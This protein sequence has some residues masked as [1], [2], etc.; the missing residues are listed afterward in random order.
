MYRA[1]AD[2]PP[3]PCC[4]PPPTKGWTEL[5]PATQLSSPHAVLGGREPGELG[6]SQVLSGRHGMAPSLLQHCPPRHR[7]RCVTPAVGHHNLS[8]PQSFT[9]TRGCAGPR[10]R[11]GQP[12]SLP[13]GKPAAGCASTRLHTLLCNR[14]LRGASSNK[15]LERRK[16]N[17]KSSCENK[18]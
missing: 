6:C 5:V 12:R 9:N 2:T 18:D 3:Q 10:C 11:G 8:R 7:T 14:L 13:L 15:K 4:R 17:I 16:G 1:K